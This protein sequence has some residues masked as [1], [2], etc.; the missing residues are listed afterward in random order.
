MLSA[1]DRTTIKQVSAGVNHSLFLTSKRI[2]SDGGQVLG[3]GSNG[4]F[5]L[6]LEEQRIYLLP[7]RVEA[8]EG[9]VISKVSAGSHSAALSS[10][11]ELFLW[12]SGVFGTY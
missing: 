5:Q 11:G 3:C 7:T 4:Q 8:F 1:L 9:K 2:T 6:G 10:A 12:G